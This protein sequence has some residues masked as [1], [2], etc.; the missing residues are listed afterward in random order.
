LR[1]SK[2]HESLDRPNVSFA[3]RGLK[4]AGGSVAGDELIDSFA[5]HR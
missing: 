1:Y 5:L 4:S 2:P 3:A